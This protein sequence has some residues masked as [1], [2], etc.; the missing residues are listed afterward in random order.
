[1]AKIG[2]LRGKKDE[3]PGQKIPVIKTSYL[4]ISNL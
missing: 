3:T 2:Y 4:D 1:V